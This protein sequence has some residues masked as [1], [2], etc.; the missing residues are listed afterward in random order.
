LKD[1]RAE[2]WKLGGKGPEKTT[3]IGNF[4]PKSC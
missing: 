2:H 3:Y 1:G 4:Q